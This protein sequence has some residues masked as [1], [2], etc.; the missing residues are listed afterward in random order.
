MSVTVDPSD[1]FVYVANDNSNN[2]S[3]YTIDS[4]TGALTPVT[5]SPFASGQG[6]GSVAVDPSGQFAYVGNEDDSPG[7][8]VSGYTIDAT[9][10]A[11]TP[12]DGSPFLSGSGGFGVT[13]APSGKF[14]YVGSGGGAQVT[15]FS[16]NPTTGVPTVVAGSPFLGAG[17]GSLSIGVSPS[18][19]FVYAVGG[20]NISAFSVNATTGKL[21][22]VKGS[23]F[24]TGDDA[25]YAT[26]DPAG[27]RLY[28]TSI[29]GSTEVW[30]Y[31]IAASGALT[32]LK[33]VRTPPVPGGVALLTGSA[34]VTYTPKFAYVAN[35]GS[36]NISAYTIKATNGHI[37]AVSGSPFPAGGAKTEPISVTVDP[38]GQFVYVASTS[39]VGGSG[40]ISASIINASTGA[41]TAVTG[42]PFATGVNY[43]GSLAVDP[44]GRFAYVGNEIMVDSSYV[45]SSF[46]IDAT[47][48]AL[49][50][51]SY[52]S[53][54][55]T[56]TFWVTTHPLGQFVYAT[57]PIGTVAGLSV[58]STTGALT[59][60]TDSPYPAQTDP[61]S[62]SVD[63]SGKFAYVA[64]AV[65]DTITA[66]A[67]NETTGDLN[68]ISG[69]FGVAAGTVPRSVVTTGIVH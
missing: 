22:S 13:V 5:G 45:I 3:A 20:D 17:T 8:D 24:A 60:L 29:Y 54:L 51:V 4:D 41:L 56:G 37:T 9:T 32:V 16:I 53:P 6:P 26:M 67:I 19:K 38:S 18:S 48:G 69:E 57:E 31:K 2:I 10:G 49:T 42:S 7:G 61:I 36:N 68:V 35:S 44:S 14:G 34:G 47:N 43:P 30:T 27:T 46:A 11:L 15:A 12:M 28:V 59:Q 50:F 62:V 21:T 40:N 65:Q 55:G 33:K 64:N 58:N 63:P 66:Y 39:T 1:H 52:S 25:Y 23:P